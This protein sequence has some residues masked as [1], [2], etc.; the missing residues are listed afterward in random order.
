MIAAVTRDDVTKIDPRQIGG[1]KRLRHLLPLLQPLHDAGCQRDR[2][3]N[4]QLHFDEYVTL[5]LLYLFNPL[6]DS[7]R[8][9]QQAAAVEKVSAQLGVK[10]FSLGSFSESCR[11][12]DPQKLKAIVEQLSAELNPVGRDPRLK[13]LKQILTAVDGTVL[14]AISS[15]AAAWWLPFQDG[16]SKYAWRLHTHFDVEHG[17]PSDLQLTDAR[18]S[19]KSDEKNVLRSKL[20]KDHCYILDRWYA[21]FVL[22]NDIHAID[23]SYVCRIKENSVFEVSQERLLSDAAL[24]AGVVR[25]AVVTMGLTSKPAARPNHPIRLIIIEA[26]EH[27][28]R[29]G[30]KGNNAGPGN[31]GTIVIATNLLEVPAEIIALIYLYRYTIEIFFRF[32]KQILG[33]RH[34]ISTKP[35]GIMIQMYCAVIA[36]LLINLWTGAKPSKRTVEMLAFFFMGVASEAEMLRHI[37]GL[38]KTNA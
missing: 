19:G 16:S 35:E 30:R 5:V 8:G 26:K 23:S 7:L 24:A 18:C 38:K 20:Q 36:C 6:I 12:F 1:L 32:L 34:L 9:L 29:G 14:D 31:K 13:D 21:Q 4:R 15:V 28:K 11:I 37:A 10:R 25:D 33:C 17:V 2:A 22:F 3:G 27:E